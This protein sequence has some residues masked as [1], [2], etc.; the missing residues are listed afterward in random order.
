MSYAIDKLGSL[1]LV[2]GS[3]EYEFDGGVHASTRTVKP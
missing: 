3:A 2:G 1:D